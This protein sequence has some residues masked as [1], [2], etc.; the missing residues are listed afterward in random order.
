MGDLYIQTKTLNAMFRMN[1]KSVFEHLLE[2]HIFLFLLA[3]LQTFINAG[4]KGL[5]HK[6]IKKIGHP[7]KFAVITF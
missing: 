4:Q 6:S 3:T 2:A 5:Y 1:V 7:K